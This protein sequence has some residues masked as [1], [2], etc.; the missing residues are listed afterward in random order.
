MT[1]AHMGRFHILFLPLLA[2]G[3]W[4]PGRSQ[5][6]KEIVHLADRKGRGGTSFAEIT[7][8]IK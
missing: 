5:N 1:S 3:G 7:I 8:Q 2:A 4:V 6:A